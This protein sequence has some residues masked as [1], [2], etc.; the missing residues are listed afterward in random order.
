MLHKQELIEKWMTQMHDPV[1]AQSILDEVDELIANAPHLNQFD[2]EGDWIADAEAI[3]ERADHETS[4]MF[5]IAQAGF[6][7]NGPRNKRKRRL[8][9]TLFSSCYLC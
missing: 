3:V 4:T 1:L 8:S 7:L 2:T 6:S 9:T 5:R